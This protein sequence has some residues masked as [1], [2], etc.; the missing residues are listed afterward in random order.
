M[1]CYSYTS[2]LTAAGAVPQLGTVAPRFFS[3]ST[4]RPPDFSVG[5]S[6]A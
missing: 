6:V 3:K 4:R 1:Y 5:T 2:L